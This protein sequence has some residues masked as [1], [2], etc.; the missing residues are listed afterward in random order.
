MDLHGSNP[1]APLK[2]SNQERSTFLALA[3]PREQSRGPIEAVLVCNTLGK[4]L[5][6]LH[7]SNPVAPLK[8]RANHT[9]TQPASTNLHG[10]NPVAPLK[11]EVNSHLLQVVLSSPREQSRGP[12]EALPAPPILVQGLAISTGAIPWP[13]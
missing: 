2:P 13:H 9:G 12:I 4:C 3:S 7:G 1:V 5:T 11:R 10:S 8:Q 6:D